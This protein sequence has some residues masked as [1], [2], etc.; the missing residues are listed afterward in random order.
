MIG[1]RKTL[2]VVKRVIEFISINMMDFKSFWNRSNILFPNNSVARFVFVV[3]VSSFNKQIFCVEPY[4]IP[5]SYDVNY[6][7]VSYHKSIGIVKELSL[8]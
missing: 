2:K 1:F 8:C 5:S 3:K 4:H 6:R 7:D